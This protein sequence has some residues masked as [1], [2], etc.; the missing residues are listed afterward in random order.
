MRFFLALGLESVAWSLRR[1]W[2]PV[3]G[4]DLVLEVGSGG[5]P[6]FRANV[7]LDAYENTQERHWQPLV[8]D[9]PTVLGFVERLPFRDKSFDFVIASHVLEH[10]RDPEAFIAEL[11]RVAKAGYI[12]VPD[13]LFERLNPYNDH[14]L[15]ITEREGRLIIRGKPASQADPELVE[16]YEQQLKP[17]LTGETMRRH[18]FHFH[19]RHYWRDSIDFTYLNPGVALSWEAPAPTRQGIYRPGMRAR[20]AGLVLTSC[21]SLFSQNRRNRSLNIHTLLQCPACRSDDLEFTGDDVRCKN[22]GK[23]YACRNGIPVMVAD[24]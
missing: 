23:A 21:R 11:Q 19:V 15:E 7:L 24:A 14:R 18:P 5:N 20:I 2:C 16:L 1:L 8:S 4:E 22:C 9:R 12:E 3:S 17:V 6:Y 10:S 13:A